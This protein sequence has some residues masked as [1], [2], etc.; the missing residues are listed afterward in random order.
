VEV[1]ETLLVSAMF[2]TDANA[3]NNPRAAVTDI[4]QSRPGGWFDSIKGSE[5]SM[6]ESGELGNIVRTAGQNSVGTR[7]A[8]I[9]VSTKNEAEAFIL[10]YLKQCTSDDS[11]L[12]LIKPT[13][14]KLIYV[15]C[16]ITDSGISLPSLGK[17]SPKSAGRL[18]LIKTLLI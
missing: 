2:V 14:D 13:V 12:K 18:D 1:H 11:K 3:M 15:P 9:P 5:T 8:A 6:S 10:R 4:Y 17:M 16:E 7:K